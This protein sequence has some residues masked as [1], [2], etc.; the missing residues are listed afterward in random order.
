M[1]NFLI[2]AVA[3]AIGVVAMALAD[4]TGWLIFAV[5]WIAGYLVGV[6]E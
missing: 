2:W 4:W 3:V 5:A 1:R 6:S